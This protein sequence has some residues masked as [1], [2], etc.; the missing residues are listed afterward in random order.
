MIKYLLILP[1]F[2]LAGPGDDSIKELL[3]ESGMEMLLESAAPVKVIGDYDIDWVCARF[4]CR[5]EA[6]VVNQSKIK[7]YPKEDNNYSKSQIY[8][9]LQKLNKINYEITK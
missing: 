2:V 1:L 8:A 5:Y 6:V 4:K 9:D 7:F 3:T